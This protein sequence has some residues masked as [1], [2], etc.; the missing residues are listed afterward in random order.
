ME[1][2]PAVSELV[3]YTSD[4]IPHVWEKVKGHIQR[5]L[6]RGSNY[7][8]HDIRMGLCT[9]QMQLWCSKNGAEI[10]A[11]VVTTIQ[12]KGHLRW[13]LIL[14]AGGKNME[15]WI[16][17]LPTMEDFARDNGC[18]EMRIYGRYGWAKMTGYDVIYTKMTRQL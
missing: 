8:L 16:Q 15:E 7:S 2:P 5:A 10:E 11:A 14:T 1:C 12:N 18:D 3:G 9:A 4:Q 13:C 17:W 6:D